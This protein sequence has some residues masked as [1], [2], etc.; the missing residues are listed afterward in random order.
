M[1][2]K[3][4]EIARVAPMV[5]LAGLLSQN[6]SESKMAADKLLREAKDYGLS[7]GDYLNVRIDPRKS[8]TPAK[9]QL[10]EG[11]FLSGFDA[12]MLELNLPH[13]DNFEQG[14]LLQAAS[15]TF[16]TFPGTRAM[17]P[18]VVDS[19]LRWKNRQSNLETLAP[20]ISQS[21]TIN[22]AEMIST[23]VNDDK[24]ERDTYSIAEGGEIPVR[25]IRTSQTAVGI[26]KHGSGIRT[27][28][29]FERRASLDILTPFAARVAREL[30][31]SKVRAATNVLVNGDGVNAAAAVEGITVYGGVA[32]NAGDKTTFLRNQYGALMA[33]MVNKAAAG[34]PIDTIAGNLKMYLELLMMFTPTISN[35]TSLAEAMATRGGPAIDVS[36]PLMNGNVKFALSSSMPDNMLLGFSKMETLEEVIEAGSSIAEN[37][38]AVSNQTVTYY[39]TENSGFRLAFGDTRFMLN[40]AA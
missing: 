14:V 8:E 32:Y 1:N 23:V 25:T 7:L 11:V 19:M 4:T 37:E 35:G 18:E 2:R 33:W 17:F 5:A 27:T 15:D 30:E 24:N 3:L 6:P 16:Q 40:L 10:K 36:L 38:K 31:M 34:T 13:R 28:Y 21:R 12:S 26:F 22:G 39:R 29:E 9:F 20:F